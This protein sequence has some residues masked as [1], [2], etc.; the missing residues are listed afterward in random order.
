MKTT[1]KRWLTTMLLGIWMITAFCSETVLA[2][3][4]DYAELEDELSGPDIHGEGYCV[5]DAD[6]GEVLLY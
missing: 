3:P 4:E 5:M 6:T 2:V 1:M